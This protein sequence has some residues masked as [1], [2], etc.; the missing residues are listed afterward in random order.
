MVSTRPLVVDQ[1]AAALALAAEVGDRTAV[2]IDEGLDADHRADQVLDRSG[3]RSGLRA[4]PGTARASTRVPQQ[5]RRCDVAK[6]AHPRLLNSAAQ[7]CARANAGR[8]SPEALSLPTNRIISGSA[9]DC[10]G[11]MPA[12]R[13]LVL[14]GNPPRSARR[15]RRGRRHGVE[16]GLRGAAAGT[17]AG[18]RRRRLLSGG[19]RRQPA[20]RPGAR[21]L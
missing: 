18:R 10:E 8:A 14:E 5:A 17:A 21:G 6:N 3:G 11:H 4:R 2:G 12:P 20:R 19:C 13:L 15:A 16:R 1:D 7:F 9:E